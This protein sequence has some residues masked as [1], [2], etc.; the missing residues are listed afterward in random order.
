MLVV[1]ENVF[2]GSVSGGCV[3]ADVIVGALDVIED[4]TPRRLRFGVA[5]ETAWQAGLPCGGTIEVFVERLSGDAAIA[6]AQ[7]VVSA[8]DER[9]AHV[10]LTDLATG[11]TSTPSA[12][13]DIT[14]EIGKRIASGRNGIVRA[15]S[16]HESGDFFVH[17]MRPPPRLLV[18]GA[19]HIAQALAAF[20]VPLQLAVTIV[21]PRESFASANRFPSGD[22]IHAWPAEA[23]GTLGLDRFTAVA[24]V[25]HVDRIDDEA[26]IAAIGSPACYIGALGSKRNHAKRRERLKMAGL[27]DADVDRIRC[28]IGLDIGAVTPEEIALAIAGEVVL[29]LRGSKHSAGPPHAA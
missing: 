6:R 8:R 27:S 3:E 24:V 5:D 10:T 14:G 28:P 15:G 1:S 22:L 17:T 21:D 23:F 26:L 19:T 11:A 2:F 25:A 4:G 7:A 16:S 20:S 12:C 29:S 13:E 9:R 18:V